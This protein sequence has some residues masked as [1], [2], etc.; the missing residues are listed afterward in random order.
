[1]TRL[2]AAVYRVST[3]YSVSHAYDKTDII[4]DMS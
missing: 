2:F 4:H 1:V 3:K